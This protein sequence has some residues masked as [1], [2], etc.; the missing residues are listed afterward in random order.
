MIGPSVAHAYLTTTSQSE[1]IPDTRPDEAKANSE[2]ED[3]EDE[4]GEF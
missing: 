2:D 3:G 4:A 1:S